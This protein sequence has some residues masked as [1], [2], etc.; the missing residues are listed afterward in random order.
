MRQPPYFRNAVLV[1]GALLMSPAALVAQTGS[2][3]EPVRYVGGP[4]VHQQSHDGQLRPAIGVESFQV[5]RA[6]RT[7]PELADNFGWTYNHGPNIVY[8]NGRFYVEYLS[9]P[10]GEHIAPGQ[11]LLCSSVDGRHWDAPQVVFPIYELG[12][13]DP[14]GTTAM[15]HQRMGFFIAPDGRLLVMAFYGHA[16]NPFG[17]GGIGRVVREAYKDGTFGP[18]YFLRYNTPSGWGENNTSYPLLQA[19][20]RQRFRRGL[21]RPAR[22]SPD[23]RAMVGRRASRR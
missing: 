12:P 18:I 2:I 5:M 19:L 7:H 9:N 6:N 17:K 8:W 10:V 21:R 1:A 15:M 20:D 3:H 14:R 11:T 23:A 13:P 16:P 22:Q 4:V